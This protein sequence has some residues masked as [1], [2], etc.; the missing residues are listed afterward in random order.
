MGLATPTAATTIGSRA[1]LTLDPSDPTALP[2][3]SR[4]DSRGTPGDAPD[5][6]Q[7]EEPIDVDLDLDLAT[8]SQ[9]VDTLEAALEQQRETRPLFVSDGV[10]GTVADRRRVRVIFETAAGSPTRGVAAMLA[11]RTGTARFE[12]LR[13]FSGF[14]R[15]VATVGPQ[16]LANLI[17]NPTVLHIELDA[18]HRPSL[19][20]SIPIIQADLSHQ[21]EHDGDGTVVAIID[22]GIDLTHPMFADRIVEEAC[23]S[24]E[25]DCP[26][27]LS[28]MLG[29]GAAAPCGLPGCAHG[30]R[31]TGIA[32]GNEPGG[33][34]IGVAPHANLIAIQVFSNVDGAPG[35]YSSD[36]LAAYQHLL[37]LTDFY[38]IAAV[39]LSLG[40][41]AYTAE[42]SC[43]QAA[44]SHFAAIARL[45]ELGV[46]TVAAAGNES[47]TNALTTPACLSNVI[48]VGSTSNADIVSSFSNSASFLRMLA[49]GEAVET[50]RVGGGSSSVSGTSMA[51]P[52]VSGAL[53]VIREAVPDA[54]VNEIENA[55]ALSGL[56]VTD[57][58]NG[59]TTPRL[60]IQ[61]AIDLLESATLPPPDSEDPP[62]DGG[63][64]GTPSAAN[65]SSS[66]GGG[67]GCG[68]VGLEPFLV[69]GLVRWGR[70]RGRTRRSTSA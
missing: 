57:H 40:G 29:P 49:P 32:V 10:I 1:A 18:V 15:G 36:I 8:T 59:V 58:R 44:S 20:D 37:G 13:V 50:A 63:G 26:N 47:F 62:P 21:F 67:G 34:L 5:R 33:T 42:A 55:I 4:A 41:N 3:A 53:A 46:I 19:E 60:R 7:S 38:P 11:G 52:H 66:S 35:A 2:T 17:E 56:P 14:D 16:A 65:T 27:D 61:D 54:T 25:N 64:S 31:V 12:G 23:F 70:L 22:T 6:A 39:N 24:L 48:G 9:I 45:R 51:T 69:L 68:L 28:E 30:T 43:D